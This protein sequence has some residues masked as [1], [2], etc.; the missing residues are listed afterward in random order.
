VRK[1]IILGCGKQNRVRQYLLPFSSEWFVFSFIE[2]T[3][4]LLFCVVVKFGLLRQE[5]RR[6]RVC[7]SRVVRRILDVRGR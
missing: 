4:F 7:E 3:L 6:F 1:T 5:E 2:L